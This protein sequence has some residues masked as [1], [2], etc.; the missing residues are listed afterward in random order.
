[1]PYP[2]SYSS[3]RSSRKSAEE[4]EALDRQFLQPNKVGQLWVGGEWLYMH[5]G[6]SLICFLLP[7]PSVLS[8][9]RLS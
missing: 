3:Y 1:M 6:S 9:V 2:Y 4:G 5:Y 7:G 8:S